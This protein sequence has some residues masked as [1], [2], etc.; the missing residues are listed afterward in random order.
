[1]SFSVDESEVKKIKGSYRAFSL[2]I[3]FILLIC[4]FGTFAFGAKE[5]MLLAIGISMIFLFMLYVLVPIVVRGYPR[6]ILMWTL[7]KK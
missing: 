2:F 1:M 4:L 7:D 5:N 3:C 6:K